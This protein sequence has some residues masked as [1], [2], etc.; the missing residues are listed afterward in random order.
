MN[1]KIILSIII[2][3]ILFGGAGF[4][5]GTRFNSGKNQPQNFRGARIDNRAGA[6]LVNG[7]IIAKDNKSITVKLSDGGSKI[8]FLSDTT[9]IGKMASGTPTDLEIGKNVMVNGKAN[10]DGSLTAQSIQ[11]RP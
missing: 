10:S 3:A 1:K 5:F 8:I 7:E 11:M 6:N 4:Y 2:T 9:E